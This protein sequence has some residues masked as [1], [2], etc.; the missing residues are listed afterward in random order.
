MVT[1]GTWRLWPQFDEKKGVELCFRYCP[2]KSPGTGGPL[3]AMA[4]DSDG[5]AVER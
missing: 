2:S 4:L 3:L 5:K 1:Q